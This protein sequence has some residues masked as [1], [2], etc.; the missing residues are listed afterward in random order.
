MLLGV[1]A[2]LARRVLNWEKRDDTLY[3][4]R[5]ADVAIR[6]DRSAW[7][8]RRA[9]PFYAFLSAAITKRCFV[10]FPPPRESWISAARVERD[11]SW[12][13]RG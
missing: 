5:Y 8:D 12:N 6:F 11:C 7:A 2:G 9:G 10:L 4:D 1:P 13:E 3:E